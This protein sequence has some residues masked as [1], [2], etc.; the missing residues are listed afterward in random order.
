MQDCGLCDK[1]FREQDMK[2][3]SAITMTSAFKN[4]LLPK[5]EDLQRIL[6]EHDLTRGQYEEMVLRSARL[7]TS[8]V[9]FCP[10]CASR[11]IEKASL[12]KK[13][14]ATALVLLLAVPTLFLSIVFTV[15]HAIM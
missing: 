13:G 4:G 2:S 8:N 9:L 5:E 12:G 7:Q 3:I 1:S 15:A 10:D 11:V 14:C 6:T